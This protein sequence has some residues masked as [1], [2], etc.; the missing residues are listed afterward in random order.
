MQF[1]LECWELPLLRPRRQPL[2]IFK[3]LSP[4]ALRLLPLAIAEPTSEKGA[5]VLIVNL[6]YATIV[7]S[8]LGGIDSFKGIPYTQPHAWSIR[9]NH[10]NLS[11][12]TY[13]L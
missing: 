4:F 8:N 13:G 9:L 12:P 6:Q 2:S 7:G 3:M 1:H 10:R 5:L 11:P